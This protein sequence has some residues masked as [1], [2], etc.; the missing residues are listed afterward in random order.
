M[1]MDPVSSPT[2][3]NT[4]VHQSD[5]FSSVDELVIE[6]EH[7]DLYFEKYITPWIPALALVLPIIPLFLHYHVRVTH[8]S[9]SFGYQFSIVSKTVDRAS[10][11]S[12][13]AIDHIHGLNDWGGWGIRGSPHGTIAYICKNGPG[14]KLTT[15]SLGKEH[16]YVFNCA[17]PQKVCDLLGHSKIVLY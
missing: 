13:E 2:D 11:T 15:V 17:E 14:L 9:V 16:S 1:T 4:D 7:G 5:T 8:D 6:E 3:P 12:V 10:I